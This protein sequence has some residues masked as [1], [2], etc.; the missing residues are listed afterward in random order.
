VKQNDFTNSPD[1]DNLQQFVFDDSSYNENLQ[2]Y[3]FD[4]LK[5]NHLDDEEVS[6]PENESEN[7]TENDS[8]KIEYAAKADI[9]AN[10][11]S[12][13]GYTIPKRFKHK[14]IKKFVRSVFQAIVIISLTT[15]ILIAVFDWNEYI[16]VSDGEYKYDN[17]FI[18]LSYFG[19]DRSRKET[20]IDDDM[21]EKHLTAL[22][23]SGYV[24]ISQ[25]DIIDYYKNGKNLPERAVYL[26]F[27]DGRRD[28]S[29]FA[30]PILEKVNYKASM[31]TYAEKFVKKD[32]KFL[33]PEDLENM[34]K[35]SFWELGT[36]GYRF[37][38]INVF[39]RY[40]NFVGNI[41]Q[42]QY[43]EISEYMEDDYNHYLMDFIRDKNRISIETR[44]Q[45]E[46]R[47]VW[48]YDKMGELYTKKIGMVPGAYII[49]H[50]NGLD[51]DSNELVRTVNFREA[52]KLFNFMYTR[53][54]ESVNTK[55]DDLFNLT[56]MEVLPYWQTN[57]LLMRVKDDTKK[58]MAFVSGEK[59]KADKWQIL[60]GAAEFEQNNIIVTSPPDEEGLIKLNE[61][62]V[63]SDFTL[64]STFGGNIIGQQTVY[65]RMDEEKKNYVSLRLKDN[66]VYI[67]RCDNGNINEIKSFDLRTAVD[68][69]VPVSDDQMRRA[70]S[71]EEQKLKVEKVLYKEEE[72]E[73]SKELKIRQKNE[74][75]ALSVEDGSPEYIADFSV[76]AIGERKVVVSLKGDKMSL[77]VNDVVLDDNIELSGAISKGFIALGAERSEL[78]KRDNVYDAVFTDLFI[79]DVNN[80][81]NVFFD[82][83]LLGKEKVKKYIDESFGSIVDW[84]VENL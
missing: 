50:A 48:D 4:E 84:F 72:A 5:E 43:N 38:Y 28:S 70:A 29:L 45:M 32:S 53:E 34:V 76:N 18:T 52:K 56:R 61:R 55:S 16:P 15:L 14:N 81:E 31:M 73:A 71:V 67:E 7:K 30:Q 39:D 79:A 6:E 12:S 10:G 40:E 46:E 51:N 9:D 64:S 66:I 8:E 22:K 59:N 63:Y 83:R 80:I 57:H 77:I 82:S 17:G 21:L 58:D 1:N 78:N 27:E 23:N 11:L 65:M 24:T 49:M 36:N 35:N 69:P 37:E 2:E 19:V 47:L 20:L 42:D 33:Q 54:G 68:K 41:D 75:N 62:G 44:D 26:V 25:Q 74:K 60:N 3:V 13:L